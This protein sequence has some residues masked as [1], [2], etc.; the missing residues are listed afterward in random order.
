MRVVLQIAVLL[1]CMVTSAKANDKN[2]AEIFSKCTVSTEYM[3]RFVNISSTLV[4]IS[5]DDHS[6]ATQ[7]QIG[8]LMNI[9]TLNAAFNEHL[10]NLKSKDS[11]LTEV[12]NTAQKTENEYLSKFFLQTVEPAQTKDLIESIIK[13]IKLCKSLLANSEKI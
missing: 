1:L 6:T 12:I 13:K 3:V 9:L 10:N 5:S 4:H 11:G 2:Q 8:S 7:W